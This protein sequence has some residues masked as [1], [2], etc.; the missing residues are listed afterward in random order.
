MSM[1][2]NIQ[3]LTSE[4]EKL[5]KKKKSFVYIS[6]F[7]IL[8]VGISALFIFDGIDYY[9]PGNM[10]Y[11]SIT[12]DPFN[13]D[14]GKI[15][16]G[17]KKLRSEDSAKYKRLC[18]KIRYIW[19]RKCIKPG[20]KTDPG[21]TYSGTGGC[22]FKGSNVIFIETNSKSENAYSIKEA[23]KYSLDLID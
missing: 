4:I 5:D 9:D 11:L 13:G 2:P 16:S 22:Y 6:I 20:E 19:E 15:I 3:E 7:I 14:R 21:F 12:A 8:V 17:I 1:E 18:T 10:C 23:I